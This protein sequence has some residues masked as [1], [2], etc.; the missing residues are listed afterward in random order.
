MTSCA[1]EIG[2]EGLFGAA[3][4]PLQ[5]FSAQLG[6]SLQALGLQVRLD[7]IGASVLDIV[8]RGGDSLLN[9]RLTRVEKGQTPLPGLSGKIDRSFFAILGAGNP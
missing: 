2:D 3:A 8:P 7:Q 1:D 5:F 4:A 9:A 6:E